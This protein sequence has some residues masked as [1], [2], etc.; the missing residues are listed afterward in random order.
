MSSHNRISLEI[1]ICSHCDGKGVI[2]Q[3]E[4]TCY[5]KREYRSWNEICKHCDGSG[6]LKKK[7]ETITTIEPY[8]TP[9]IDK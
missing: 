6:R 8:K 5:H 3:E 2:T 7:V 1:I 9:E 4:M